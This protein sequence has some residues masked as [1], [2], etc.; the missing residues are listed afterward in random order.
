MKYLGAASHGDRSY[1]LQFD[2]VG[3]KESFT[4]QTGFWMFLA[5]GDSDGFR[6]I[7]HLKLKVFAF[8]FFA[9]GIWMRRD[10][11]LCV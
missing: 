11:H 4:Q 2:A 7:Q 8:S 1:R 6:W 3:C 10:V 9:K 5:G